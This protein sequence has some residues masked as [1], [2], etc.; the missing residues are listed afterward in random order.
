MSGLN[1]PLLLLVFLG[2]ALI[3]YLA[4]VLIVLPRVLR[5]YCRTRGYPW[6]SDYWEDRAG[7]VAKIE[8][9]DRYD[10]QLFVEGVQIIHISHW[11]LRK[12]WVQQ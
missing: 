11:R 3:G 12:D 9:V 6:P 2:G 4:G 5:A 1:S 10:V 7:R 8:K